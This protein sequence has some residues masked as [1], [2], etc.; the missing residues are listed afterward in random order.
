MK[1]LTLIAAVLLALILTACGTETP[2][3]TLTVAVSTVPPTLQP[4]LSPPDRPTTNAQSSAL[5]S[6]S[7][8]SASKLN[9]SA[10]VNLQAVTEDELT[11]C[12]T[13]LLFAAEQHVHLDSNEPLPRFDRPSGF[14]R[15]APRVSE[16]SDG[17]CD[18]LIDTTLWSQLERDHALRNPFAP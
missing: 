11:R 3:P 5:A 6:T 16:L 10:L 8:P 13:F 7:T 1:R 9:G 17:L 4:R 2:K 12:V 14:T 15:S 18:G